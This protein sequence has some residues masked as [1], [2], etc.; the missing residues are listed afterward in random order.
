MSDYLSRQETINTIK[1]L[2]LR[3]STCTSPSIQIWLEAKQ[4]I[5]NCIEQI[6]PA[7]VRPVVQGKW[8]IHQT[9]IGTNYTVC[10]ECKNEFWYRSDYGDITKIDLSRT[11]YCPN[12]GAD[13]SEK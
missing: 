5:C 7:D 8:I 2:P 4:A 6:K 3:I 9:K 12:C 13:M 11:N 10:S 1:A